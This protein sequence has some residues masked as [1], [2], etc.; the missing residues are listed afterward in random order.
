MSVGFVNMADYN[1][2]FELQFKTKNDTLEKRV[3]NLENEIDELK[4]VISDLATQLFELI[5]SKS[6]YSNSE[7]LKKYVIGETEIYNTDKNVKNNP[8][9]NHGDEIYDNPSVVVIKKPEN[10]TDDTPLLSM[11]DIIDEQ[12]KSYGD[13]LGAIPVEILEN[14]INN[15]VTTN[16]DLGMTEKERMEAFAEFTRNRNKEVND[17]YLN[18]MKRNGY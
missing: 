1:Q 16:F 17:V 5:N 8:E 13:T 11:Q 12:N 7:L 6:E 9:E 10:I 14:R 15:I 2:A 18:T 4:V 3:K